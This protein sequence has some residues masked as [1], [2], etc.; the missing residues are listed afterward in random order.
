MQ[1]KTCAPLDNIMGSFKEITLPYP[2][3]LADLFHLLVEEMPELRPYAPG[4]GS[5]DV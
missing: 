5:K 3:T 4:F 1:I 2:I